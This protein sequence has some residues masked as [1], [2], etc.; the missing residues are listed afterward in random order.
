MAVRGTKLGRAIRGG[1]GYAGI[2][3]ARGLCRCLS[4]TDRLS[5]SRYAVDRITECQSGTEGRVRIIQGFKWGTY[6]HALAAAFGLS[7]LFVAVPMH[8]TRSL[9]A[10][11][12][13]LLFLA[14]QTFRS[15]GM[16]AMPT[17]EAL[18]YSPSVMFRKG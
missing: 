14:W 10:G 3:Y 6:C 4:G 9:R 16:I 8:I 18:H 7:Q 12:A 15:N 17:G 5:R 13:Y 1:P 11:A 2:R